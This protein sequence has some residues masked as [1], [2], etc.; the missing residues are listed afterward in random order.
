MKRIGLILSILFLSLC[1]VSAQSAR[2]AQLYKNGTIINQFP[3]DNSVKLEQTVYDGKRDNI[4]INMFK[5]GAIERVYS[6]GSFDSIEIVDIPDNE[7]WYTTTHDRQLQPNTGYF[8]ANLISNEYHNGKGIMRFD[9]PVTEVPPHAFENYEIDNNLGMKTI[10]LPSSV[11]RIG[12]GAFYRCVNLEYIYI[13]DQVTYIDKGA[14]MYTKL[15]EITLPDVA[16]FGRNILSCNPQLQAIYSKKATPDHR[17]LIVDGR[18]VSFAPYG[19]TSYTIPEGVCEIGPDC[20][21]SYTNLT[22]IKMP[23][24]VRKI[25]E[26][27]FQG[28]SIKDIEI[29]EGVTS[30]EK[31]AFRLNDALETLTL[32]QS[33]GE[34]GESVITECPNLR[35]IYG[36]YSSCHNRALVVDGAIIGIAPYELT[37]FIT[38]PDLKTIGD[39][40]FW[41]NMTLQ[42]VVLN[43]GIREIG[44]DAFYA[45]QNLT[46][47]SFP[48]SLTQ[49]GDRILASCFNLSS[50]SGPC[51]SNDGHCLILDGKLYAFA[52]TDIS[53]YILP[54]NIKEIRPS[55]FEYLY[56]LRNIT[57]PEGLEKICNDAFRICP[58]LEK[59]NLP[60]SIKTLGGFEH[61]MQELFCGCD[62]LS[63]ILCMS[64]EKPQLLSPLTIPKHCNIYVPQNLLECF[65][66]DTEW[67]KYKI[68]GFDPTH[69]ETIYASTDYSTDG[70]TVTLHTAKIGAGIDVFIVGDGYTDR[71]IADKT[72]DS[73]M[74]KAMNAFFSEEPFLSFK[75]YFNVY[76]VVAVSENEVYSPYSSTVFNCNFG[77]G[78]QVGGN[79]IKVKDYAY[80]TNMVK[81]DENL[82]IIVI[83]SPTY[84]GTTYM[85]YPYDSFDFGCG[86]SFAYCPAGESD[87]MF[88]E[89]II[90]EAGGHGFAKLAD[91]YYYGGTMDEGEKMNVY[92]YRFDNG[93]WKN[94]DFTPEPDRIKWSEFL[95]DSRYDEQHL[96]IFEGACTYEY[97]VY[98]PTDVSIMRYNTGG[99]NAPSRQ[100]IYQRIHKLAYG[101]EWVYDHEKFVTWDMRSYNPEAV[102]RRKLQLQ[103]LSEIDYRPL[104]PPV[105]INF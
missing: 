97:G 101:D 25:C 37:E 48:S 34:L 54:S 44:N 74:R 47:I 70:M 93:W 55:A 77:Y 53:D 24:S 36:K 94:I 76:Y 16:S 14:F 45:C 17:S 95:H 98:R 50:M 102:D 88:E 10:V 22:D 30:V 65:I 100:A 105:I 52:G 11:T 23:S 12:T 51:V 80:K 7:I 78:T 59:I 39:A 40:T 90:H 29:P 79:N 32:P 6:P 99:F 86:E 5:K 85:N 66:N 33:L 83:N 60:K 92:E 19:I 3:A 1:Q 8:G 71:L 69:T 4:E 38:T 31:W 15:R 21:Q 27:A 49:V 91:E 2:Y 18:M 43:E 75:D 87:I 82:Y 61:G 103:R 20:F 72:Y 46:H 26:S 68:S 57:F 81:S 96:G 9:A 64:T 13:P 56:Q 62:N 104:A 58:A 42:R 73:H 28:T 41:G 84:A 67:G 63:K 35:A 89:I